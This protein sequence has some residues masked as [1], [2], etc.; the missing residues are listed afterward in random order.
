MTEG[1]E[2]RINVVIAA[3]FS[4]ELIERFREISPR[5][6]IQ[7]YWPDVPPHVW[8]NA[9]ILYTIRHYPEPEEAPLL[10]WIQLHSAGMDGIMQR[11]I[12]QAEDVDVT[13]TSGIHATQ[14]A[15]YC[16]MM[17]LAFHYK[18]PAMMQLKAQAEW[19]RN[20]QEI[21]NPISLKGQVLGIM[22]YGSI[23]REL[24]RLARTLGMTVLAT[25]RDVKRPAESG[26]YVEPGTGDPEGEIPER[27]Y[28]GAALKSMAAECDYLVITAPLTAETR[29]SVNE[30]VLNAMKPTAVLINVARGSIVDEAALISALA[31]EKIR[32]AALDVFEE[33][34]L[35]ATSPLWNLDNVIISPHISGYC[36]DYFEKAAAV[37]A[38]NLR[39]YL[40]NRPLLNKLNRD[41]GY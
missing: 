20:S 30:A 19:P 33:E 16:L 12:I 4:D 22:G 28:P 26:S 39:R 2:N 5:L 6:N 11:R 1:Q 17:I 14:M 40:D 15:N 29:H 41:I 34:P 21:F 8:A 7:R 3:D 35:P 27:L 18:L 10:R 25:K 32:G 36:A 31:A 9:E 13:S 23:G 38:E 24:A 37:F